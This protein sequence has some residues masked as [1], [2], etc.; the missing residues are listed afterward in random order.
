MRKLSPHTSQLIPYSVALC[1]GL[2]ER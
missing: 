1:A 2:R